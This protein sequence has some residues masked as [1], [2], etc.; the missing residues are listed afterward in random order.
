GLIV[1]GV[2]QRRYVACRNAAGSP[3][4]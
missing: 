2:R 1:R 3:S 4:E